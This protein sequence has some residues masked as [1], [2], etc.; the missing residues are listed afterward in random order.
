[1]GEAGY[2]ITLLPQAQGALRDLCLADLSNGGRGIRN[3]LEAHLL[4][5]MA[6]AVF[7]QGGGSFEVTEVTRGATTT[8][9]LV[10][11]P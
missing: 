8:L 2:Q 10:R 9:T 11:R 4:N 7:D 5:P 1:V 6:R 3:Q